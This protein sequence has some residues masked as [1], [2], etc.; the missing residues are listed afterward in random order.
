MVDN[1]RA[2]IHWNS[3]ILPT[4]FDAQPAA[5]Q[6]AGHL[7]LASSSYC[8]LLLKHDLRVPSL[9]AHCAEQHHIQVSF[10][11]FYATGTIVKCPIFICHSLATYTVD[12]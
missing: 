2:E 9:C 3:F 4:W 12:L 10:N 6:V 8:S 7:S 1:R 11:Y 5:Q